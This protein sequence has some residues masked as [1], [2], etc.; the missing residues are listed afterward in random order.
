MRFS[1]IAITLQVHTQYTKGFLSV[2]PRGR[3]PDCRTSLLCLWGASLSC[4][5]QLGA[6]LESHSMSEYN[7]QQLHP[8]A[9]SEAA[10]HELRQRRAAIEDVLDAGGFKTDRLN[11]L[12]V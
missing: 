6:S 2:S 5:Q 9:V 7:A 10:L 12:K 1:R 4:R 8:L 11:K 3:V